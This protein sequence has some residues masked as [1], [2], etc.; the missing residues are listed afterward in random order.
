MS[1]RDVEKTLGKLLTDEGFCERF[2]TNPA[3]ACLYAGLELSAQELE[4]LC[5]IPRPSLAALRARLDGRI[6]RLPVHDDGGPVD[7]PR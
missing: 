7:T 5:R 1:Q 3:I 2:F 6:C 4:A